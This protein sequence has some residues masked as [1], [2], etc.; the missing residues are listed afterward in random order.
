MPE[1]NFSNPLIKLNGFQ[2]IL[3]IINEGKK[4]LIVTHVR[5]DGDAIGSV[6]G[7]ALSLKK[8]G[9][10]V[11]I[12]LSDHPPESFS[13]LLTQDY[14][15]P[16]SVKGEYDAIFSLDCGDLP[17]TGFEQDLINCRTPIVNIDHHISNLGY[18]TVNLIDPAASSAAEMILFLIH[19]GGLPLDAEVAECLYLGL[20]T[21]ARFFQNENL[22]PSAHVSGAI[23]LETGFKTN[24]ILSALTSRRT[25]PELKILGFALSHLETEMDGKLAKVLIRPQN[26]ISCEATQ[27]N[28]WASGVFNQI[29]SIKGVIVGFTLV[30]NQEGVTFCEFRSKSGFDVKEI[31]VALGGGGHLAASGCNQKLPIDAMNNRVLALLRTRLK[32]FIG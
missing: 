19:G 28:V 5:P 12:G 25:L 2:E 30:E 11:D 18:G 4:F 15:K 26:L 9:K 32:Q 27:E 7:F 31:A 29:T 17:R 22:R 6:M 10:I 13:F 8:H 1:I 24:R 21:D 20:V 16:G 3:S 23:L 14:L